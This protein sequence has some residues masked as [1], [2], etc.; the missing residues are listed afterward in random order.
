MRQG[1]N[2][3]PYDPC[4]TNKMVD[5]A[6]LTVCWRVDDLKASHMKPQVVGDFIDWVKRQC[7]TI[8]GK[9]DK[10]EVS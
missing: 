7:G 2:I 9:S 10:R 8:G 3:N 5:G 1:L 6:Q 4:V